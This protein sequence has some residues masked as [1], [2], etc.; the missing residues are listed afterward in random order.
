MQITIDNT[1][2]NLSPDY[3]EYIDLMCAAVVKP[4]DPPIES[5]AE[6]VKKI[7]A[8]NYSSNI[9]QHASVRPKAVAAQIKEVETLA[10]EAFKRS[11]SGVFA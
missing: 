1:P 3:D 9:Q 8:D 7:L 11:V 4:G 2:I 5:R 10:A 6:M